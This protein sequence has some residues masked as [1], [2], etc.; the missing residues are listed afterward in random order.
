MK[1]EISNNYIQVNNSHVDVSI[2]ATL[3][4]V[5]WRSYNSREACCPCP[6]FSSNFPLVRRVRIIR[7]I[8]VIV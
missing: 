8:A 3:C 6:R 2:L 4:L 1:A 5:H 7:I